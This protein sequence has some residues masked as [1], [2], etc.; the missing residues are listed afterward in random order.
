MSGPAMN[1]ALCAGANGVF[2]AGKECPA[3]GPAVCQPKTANQ[4]AVCN[5]VSPSQCCQFNPGAPNCN[6]VP[7]LSG[8]TTAVLVGLLVLGGIAILR[9]RALA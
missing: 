4:D 3:Q 8:R 7:V 2:M 5:G 1:G 6:S 9:R